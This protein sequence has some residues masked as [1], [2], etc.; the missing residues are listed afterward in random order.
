MY[1]AITEVNDD[2]H[3][4]TE[5]AQSMCTPNLHIQDTF[6]GIHKFDWL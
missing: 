2:I 6:H 5:N 4:V 1:A 3:H